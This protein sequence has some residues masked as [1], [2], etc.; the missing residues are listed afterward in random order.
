MPGEPESQDWTTKIDMIIETLMS[1][2]YEKCNQDGD[3][4]IIQ[5]VFKNKN[6]PED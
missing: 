3:K 4:E 5:D 2:V 6:G 1:K